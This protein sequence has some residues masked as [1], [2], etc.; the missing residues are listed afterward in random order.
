MPTKTLDSNLPIYSL[1]SYKGLVFNFLEGDTL[2]VVEGD[3][4]GWHGSHSYK[5]KAE[6]LKKWPS[7]FWIDVD[8]KVHLI[9]E[10]KVF[11]KEL[12]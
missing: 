2:D 12:K 7:H 5:V 1:K 3:T 10:L 11:G 6:D 8:N 9:C 4:D